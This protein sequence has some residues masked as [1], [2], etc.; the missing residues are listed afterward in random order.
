[1]GFGCKFCN[2]IDI[3]QGKSEQQFSEKILVKDMLKKLVCLIFTK[4]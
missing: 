1:M 4:F 2:K 3:L